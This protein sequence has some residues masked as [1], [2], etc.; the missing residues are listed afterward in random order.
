[1]SQQNYEEV[2]QVSPSVFQ[3][4]ISYNSLGV[5]WLSLFLMSDHYIVYHLRIVYIHVSC[6][7]RR[8]IDDCLIF[9]YQLRFNIAR[10]RH[11]YWAVKSDVCE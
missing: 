2:E 10:Q 6:I 1:M 5:E 7:Y 8:R 3:Q 11:C 9:A 4:M